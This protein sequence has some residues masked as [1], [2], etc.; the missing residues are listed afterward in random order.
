VAAGVPIIVVGRLRYPSAGPLFTDGEQIA[1]PAEVA[2]ECL[3]RGWA[4]PV[5]VSTTAVS[6]P[7]VDRMV[8]GAVQKGRKRSSP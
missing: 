1:V 5:P 4:K 2:T 7:P 6:A 8:R 3:A